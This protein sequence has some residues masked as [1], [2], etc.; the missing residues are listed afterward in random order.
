MDIF[1]VLTLIGGLALFLY[2]MDEMGNGLKKLS[3]GKL[4]SILAKLTSNKYKGF[5]L[6]FLVTAII[7][8]SSATTVMLVG[9]VNSG[10]MSLTQSIG[11]IFGANVGTTVTAWLVS[12]TNISDGAGTIL[13][14]FKPS[15]FTPI[16]GIIGVLLLMMS[17]KDKN[18][19]IGTIL[20][21]FTVLMFGMDAMSEAM[22]GLQNA[23]WFGELMVAFKNPLLGVL[24]GTLLTAIIQSSS[25]SVGILQALSTT[26]AIPF[27][28]AFPIVLGQNIGTTI[29]PILS[30]L[31]GNTGAKRVAVACLYIKIIGVIVFL[32][33]YYI[34]AAFV[35]FK[36]MEEGYMAN[37]V[38]IAVFHTVFNIISSVLLLPFSKLF[39]KLAVKTFKEKQTA[40]ED[41]TF[42]ILDTRFLSTPSFAIAK[43]RDLIVDMVVLTKDGF[44]ESLQLMDKYDAQKDA[45][46]REKE[47]LVDRYE[48]E[49][50]SYLVRL[51]EQKLSVEHSREVAKL[52][53]VV[54]DIERISDHSVN[55]VAVAKEMHDKNIVFSDDAT[56]EIK[57]LS[58]AVC[59]IIEMSSIAL[60]END[61]M[62]ATRIEPLEQIIDKLQYKMKSN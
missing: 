33:L 44:S 5:I 24:I 36:F 40:T 48:D 51:S 54:G 6:G 61:L 9:F 43:C 38:N 56:S 1:S 35:S 12:L 4:E 62:L 49:L 21:G 47:N 27:S 34:V 2:G 60:I 57:V 59:D 32:A 55:L 45:E 14:L 39:E 19:N 50:S 3:G 16:L 52:L 8:S 20:I 31:N 53:H 15:S 46:I 7:Q 28:V 17:K 25:A 41:K 10:I 26:G 30:A 37:P 11:I 18:K 42:A 58:N 23:E 29:T 22:E 13:K